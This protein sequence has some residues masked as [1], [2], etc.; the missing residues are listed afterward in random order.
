MP[1]GFLAFALTLVPG[2]LVI[3]AGNRLA[4]HGTTQAAEGRG[5][6]VSAAGSLLLTLVPGVAMAVSSF[7]ESFGPRLWWVPRY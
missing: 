7:S 1:G 5:E 4:S 3:I 2:V 6:W